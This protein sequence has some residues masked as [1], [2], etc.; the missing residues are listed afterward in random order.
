VV[1]RV[2][3]REILAVSFTSVKFPT[4]APGDSVLMRVFVGG[5]TQPELFERDDAEIEAI[6][7]RELQSLL[8]TQGKPLFIDVA[9]HARAMPQYTLGHSE[10]VAA[11]RERQATHTGLGISGNAFDG[12]GVPDCIRNARGA[13]DALLATIVEAAQKA[14]A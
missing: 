3:N 8:G 1:P 9:R 14:V 12:V 10:R 6:V 5:A 13:A 4:R 11:I 2:E 7:L